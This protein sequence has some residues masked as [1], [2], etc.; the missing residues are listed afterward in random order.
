MSFLLNTIIRTT[1]GFTEIKEL[2][3]IRKFSLNTDKNNIQMLIT[4]SVLILI[5]VLLMIF[6]LSL[7]EV[8]FQI[9]KVLSIVYAII[10]IV[11]CYILRYKRKQGILKGVFLY[12]FIGALSFVILFV[13]LLTGTEVA[14]FRSIFN[15]WSMPLEPIALLFSLG[16]FLPKTVIRG[17]VYLVHCAITG[18]AYNQ[19]K[20]DIAFEK[21][22]AEQKAME[23]E[24]RLRHG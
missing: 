16:G 17:I 6:N 12:Q 14:F 15:W 19:I 9:A 13:F 4:A 10:H 8:P 21:K 1:N 23:E 5:N 7:R 2:F 20:K 3:K 22:I 18:N 11:I 24:S